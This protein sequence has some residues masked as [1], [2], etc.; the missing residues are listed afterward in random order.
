MPAPGAVCTQ[1]QSAPIRPSPSAAYPPEARKR[2]I[3]SR[4]PG[5]DKLRWKA[6]PSARR[7]AGTSSALQRKAHV[8][9]QRQLAATKA[10]PAFDQRDGGLGAW[11]VRPRTGGG[12]QRDAGHPR[13]A[14]PR[15]GTASRC[16][17]WRCCWRCHWSFRWSYR[18]RC[19]R[20]RCCCAWAACVATIGQPTL[21]RRTAPVAQPTLALAQGARL[22]SALLL[23]ARQR[24]MSQAVGSSA[25]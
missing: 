8:A 24:A 16:C 14:A 5:P 9:T 20:E 7:P 10:G 21:V 13:S 19:R 25:R 11:C 23:S 6:A 2:C 15:A 18:W 12:V 22:A 3:A 1:A 17:R 4:V